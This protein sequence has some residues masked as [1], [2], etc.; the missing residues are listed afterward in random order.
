M[1]QGLS[2]EQ[3]RLA[4]SGFGMNQQAQQAAEQLG[5]AGFGLNQQGKMYAQELMMQGF[6]AN[7]AARQAQEQFG[8]SAFGMSEQAQQAAE[9]YR[10]SQFGMNEANQQF[11]AQ[12]ELAVYNAYEQAKQEAGRQGLT[13]AEIEQAGQIAAANA[14]LMGDQN[15]LAASQQ[16]AD[17]SGQQQMMELERL[18]AM[19]G[20]GMQER[21]LMQQGL[22]MGY[23]DFMR[24]QAYPRE[25]LAFYSNMLQGASIAPGQTTA[26]Y[27]PQP[28]MGQQL[29]G[30]GIAGMGL[31]NAYNQGGYGGG[32]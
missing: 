6:S 14:K 32:G 18:R 29:A 25:Q 4:Q 11:E 23:Q 5:Q 10:Q 20:A 19:Q 26:T 16:L 7:E 17:V 15:K 30:A 28:S 1:N 21:G 2:Q 9:G 27:G 22:D 3:E 8:Q 13:A 12:Q 31:Y 24:Q